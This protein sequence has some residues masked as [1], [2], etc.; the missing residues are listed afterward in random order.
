MIKEYLVCDNCNKKMR[1]KEDISKAVQIIT[2][3]K[4]Y[5]KYKEQP[6]ITVKVVMNKK[7]NYIK[8]KSGSLDFCSM[9]CFQQYM[10]KL[11]NGDVG[12]SRKVNSVRL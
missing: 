7:I 11:L 1:E 3:D 10:E 9:S 8:I 5:K 12:N 2:E 6:S 4:E